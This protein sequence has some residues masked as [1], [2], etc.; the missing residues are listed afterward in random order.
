[1]MR[2]GYSGAMVA[3]HRLHHHR[4]DDQPNPHSPLVSLF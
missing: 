4:A 2:R 3:T 1:M